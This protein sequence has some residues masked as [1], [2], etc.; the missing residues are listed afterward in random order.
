MR[1][2]GRGGGGRIGEYG[3]V[4]E[5]A[6]VRE[7]LPLNTCRMMCVWECLPLL[8]MQNDVG[9]WRGVKSD[10]ANCMTFSPSFTCMLMRRLL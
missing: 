6:S 10:E 9:S 3:W 8:Y 1:E 2:C 5:S 4:G 7:C